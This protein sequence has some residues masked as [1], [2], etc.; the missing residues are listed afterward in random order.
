MILDLHTH[1]R[2]GS[3]DSNI[4]YDDLVLSAKKA[5]LDGL[6]ITEHS[7]KKSG[8]SDRISQEYDF[9][10]LE[11]FELSTEFGDVLV[12]GLDHI[13][14]SLFRL[15]DIR[16]YVIEEGGVMFS[17]HPFR[18]EITRPVMRGQT[19]NVTLEQALS[20]DLFTLVD[21]IEVV[22]GWSCQEEIDFSYRV[23]KSLD[24]CASR[25]SDAHSPEQIGSCATVFQNAITCEDDLVKQLK[26]GS[27]TPQ[28]RRPPDSV[29]LYI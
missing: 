26:Q 6:C 23:T 18:S 11:G 16:R 20:R 22:N 8:V 17:A 19:P 27:I 25:G 24:L 1:T 10:V 2:I 14:L 5:G 3:G 12:Y 13:P 15:E 4:E 9:L 28:D 7:N 21:G 29:G